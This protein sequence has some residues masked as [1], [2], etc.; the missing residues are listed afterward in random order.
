MDTFGIYSFKEAEVFF[1][2]IVAVHPW[3]KAICFGDKVVGSIMLDKG[4]TI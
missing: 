1:A 3:F 4:K 2:N